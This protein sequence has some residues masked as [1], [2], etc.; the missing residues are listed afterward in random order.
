MVVVVVV[1]KDLMGVRIA[2]E[3]RRCP[4]C[5]QK[6]AAIGVLVIP[7]RNKDTGD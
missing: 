2:K 7:A 1:V 4:S 5:V 3:R 6:T